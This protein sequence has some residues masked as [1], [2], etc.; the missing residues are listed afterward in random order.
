LTAASRESNFIFGVRWAAFSRYLTPLGSSH[1][2][3]SFLFR[4]VYDET[5]PMSLATKREMRK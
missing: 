5:Q 2:N 1:A 3:A 4:A